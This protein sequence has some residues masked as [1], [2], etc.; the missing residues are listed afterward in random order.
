MEYRPYKNLPPFKGM[1]LQNFPFIEDDF[2]AITNYQLLCKVVEYLKNI[3]NNEII[4]EE[5][6]NNLYNSYVTLKNYVDNYFSNLDV[7]E[8]INKKLDS[9]VV[10]GQFNEIVSTYIDPYLTTFNNQ[11]NAQN[12]LISSVVNG[13]PIPVDDIDN[14]TDTTKVYLLVTDGNWYYY[15]GTEWTVGGIYQTTEKTNIVT[16]YRNLMENLN[17][18]LTYRGVTISYNNGML[19]LN[20][21][22]T[23][24]IYLRL[25]GSFAHGATAGS[26]ASDS[27]IDYLTVGKS[28]QLLENIISGNWTVA[29]GQANPASSVRS[30]NNVAVLSKLRKAQILETQANRVQYYISTGA[31]FNNCL[32]SISIYET[33][34]D[35]NF[36][37]NTGFNMDGG[38]EIKAL[39]NL[40]NDI[41]YKTPKQC[42][43]VD[44]YKEYM[45]NTEETQTQTLITQGMCSDRERYIYFTVWDREDTSTIDDKLCYIKKY[46]IL[47]QEIVASSTSETAH[48]VGHGNGMCYKDGRLYIVG[49]DNANTIYTFDSTTLEFIESFTVSTSNIPNHFGGI[50]YNS[51]LNKFVCLIAPYDNYRGIA[52][53]DTEWNLEKYIK[54]DRYGNIP[55]LV[56][57]TN[58]TAGGIFTDKDYIYLIMTNVYDGTQTQYNWNAYI[59]IYD[60]N[61]NYV[62]RIAINYEHE[63]EESIDNNTSSYPENSK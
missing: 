26:I 53:Y 1:V 47:S 35:I 34:T 12:K 43:N 57:S 5:N 42:S 39:T 11:I 17:G 19:Y 4:M 38:I 25:S 62:D 36:V 20:G 51:D 30:S 45:E 61:G 41:S 9:M 8:E 52:F 44:L 48:I 24:P 15:N 55:Y 27:P 29:E 7:E 33:D 10:S 28:Y 22:A 63:A 40:I 50:D 13:N 58:A 31:Q 14:M 16:N 23:G 21:T 18:S 3:Q 56:E 60:Y 49:L 54:L 37:S 6:V 46:D 59:Y 2:D 32:I